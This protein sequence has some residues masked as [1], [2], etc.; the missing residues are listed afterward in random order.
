MES[1]TSRVENEKRKREELTKKIALLQGEL[2]KLPGVPV[3]APAS[4][5]RTTPEPTLL[6][7]ATPSPKKKRKITHHNERPALQTMNSATARPKPSVKSSAQQL[8]PKAGPSNFLS[9]LK[10][11]NQTDQEDETNE[12]TVSRTNAFSDRPQPFG[13]E[14][15]DQDL[16][17]VQ[18]F[19]VGPYEHKALFDDPHFEALE[20]HSGIR[21][22]SRIVPHEDIQ[23]HLRG[24]VYLSPSQLYS[25]VRLMPDKMAYDVPVPGDWITIA[26]VAERGPIKF[27]KA[28][29]TVNDDETDGPRGKDKGKGKG[30]DTESSK[31]SGKKYVNIKLIDFGARSKSSSGSS[32]R[33]IRGDALLTLLLFE[34]DTFDLV[35]K[36]DDD[37]VVSGRMEK[38]YRG[39]SCGAFEAM[40]KVK[41]GD[42]IALLNPKILKPFQRS[43]DTPHPVNNILAVTPSSASS[44]LVLGRSKDLGMC[45]VVKRDGKPCGSWCDK[46]VSEVC[47]FHV[48]TAV[49]RRRASRPEFS[50]GTSGMSSSAV[51][52]RPSYDPAR[53]W[54]LA[55]TTSAST[56]TTF[57]N[58]TYVVSGHVVSSVSDNIG[59]EGQAKAQ[60]QAQALAADKALKNLLKKDIEG[61]K[62]VMA[63]REAG[64]GLGSRKAGKVRRPCKRDPPDED[65]ANEAEQR[66]ESRPPP[67]KKQAYSAEVIKQLGFDPVAKFTQKR[68][69]GSVNAKLEALA[70][71][72]TTR[73]SRGIELGPKPG[74]KHRTSV[75]APIETTRLPQVD[76]DVDLDSESDKGDD[77]LGSGMI[78]LEDL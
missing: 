38:V 44:I 59:R 61:M 10:N 76:L 72:Q 18:D 52:K 20:P 31:P 54:G 40:S 71:L 39:G 49:E 47:E 48:Q 19:K 2:E 27:S 3:A 64:L 60:R 23:D 24:R 42:V 6:A 36:G 12:E 7:P 53:Q 50:A 22:S 46:R 41:E 30:K 5:R 35:A 17:I 78:D 11:V 68:E 69:V 34:A 37:G 57:S 13:G 29:V 67:A 33:A 77:E 4:P 16:A 9:R 56:V 63:A 70:N 45:T 75:R 25:C 8:P 28:P 32:K 74:V 1:A 51:A 62:A 73:M 65:P 26:V 14:T 43:N 21:L 58:P 55:P 66:E 15:R